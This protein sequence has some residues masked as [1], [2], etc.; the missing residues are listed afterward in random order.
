MQTAVLQPQLNEIQL[1][2]LRL[3][4]REMS[5]PEMDAIREILLD[6]YDQVLQEEVQK[7]IE[8]KK[9]GRLELD[10]KLNQQHRSR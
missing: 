9:I 5:K 7:V 6:Y 10:E 2:L 8:K 1:M 3:F 4:S